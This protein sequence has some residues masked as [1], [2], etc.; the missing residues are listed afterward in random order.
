MARERMDIRTRAALVTLV[1]NTIL[2]VLKFFTFA[3]TG[4]LAIL[5]EAWHSFGDIATSATAVLSTWRQVRRR[6]AEARASEDPDA[7]EAEPA[8]AELQTVES[9]PV[10]SP[11]VES[12]GEGEPSR[13]RRA[14]SV[15]PLRWMVKIGRT[16]AWGARWLWALQPEQQAALVIGVFLAIIGVVLLRKVWV[17]EVVEVSRPLV[18]GIAFLVFSLASY[19]V[20]RFELGVGEAEGSPALSA[21]GMHA[22]ADAVASLLTGISL[23]IYHFGVNVDR[24]VAGLIGVIILSF[25]AE[26]LVNLARS[27]LRK[28]GRYVLQHRTTDWIAALLDPRRM[29]RLL[30]RVSERLAAGG[31]IARALGAALRWAPRLVVLAA[32]VAYCTT[33]FISVRPEEEV[34]LER[35]GRVVR[36]QAPLQPGLHLKAPWPVDR[37]VRV[38]TRRVLSISVGNRTKDTT[39]PMIWTRQHGT[40]EAYVSGD[41]NFFYP[42]VVVHYRVKDAYA[43]RYGAVEPER[44]LQDVA[45]RAATVHFSH[46]TFY[47]LALTER[48]EFGL[49]MVAEIQAEL[50]AMGTG[51]EV[52]DV[53]VKDI[54]PPRDV[55][56]SFEGVVAAMQDHE[57]LI[58]AAEGYYNRKIPEARAQANRLVHEAHAYVAENTT[59]STGDAERFRMRREAYSAARRVTRERLYLQA[60]ARALEGRRKVI[61]SPGAGQPDLW[62]DDTMARP[63]KPKRSRSSGS[64]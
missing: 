4:S 11:P 25:S 7:G 58:N 55:A 32:A 47:D 17:A 60:M 50:D 20:S 61:V 41:D 21:D 31:A 36:P 27:A 5:A 23:I 38:P 62:M 2:T 8:T 6:A 9:P 40:D 39:V 45:H 42:Y 57:T 18:A 37:P 43:F 35:F 28:D 56:R 49:I 44:L 12:G 13:W 59:R 26:T 52:L 54:H 63:D 19:A 22:R 34:I 3:F 33:C 51:I 29:A 24:P 64:K 15:P 30:L 48:A 16:I 46:T 10:E 53:L 1:L 14:W